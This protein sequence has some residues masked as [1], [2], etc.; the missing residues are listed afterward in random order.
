MEKLIKAY[1]KKDDSEI[2]HDL[3]VIA[4]KNYLY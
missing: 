2:L 3:R 4:R 1:V